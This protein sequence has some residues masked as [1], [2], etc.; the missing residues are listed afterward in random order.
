QSMRL[1]DG[2]SVAFA[3]TFTKEDQFSN[4]NQATVAVVSHSFEG[5]NVRVVAIDDSGKS[6]RFAGSS[7]QKIGDGVIQTAYSFRNLLPEQVSHFEFQVREY[8]LTE[9]KDLPVEPGEKRA[10]VQLQESGPR[11]L[12][13][14]SEKQNE[15]V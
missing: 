7:S 14:L 15:W 1:R 9:I 8:K 12:S 11:E 5:T 3:G 13:L 2:N 6:H 10:A 4:E